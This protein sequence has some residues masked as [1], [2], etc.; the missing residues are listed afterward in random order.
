MPNVIPAS[1]PGICGICG[2]KYEPNTRIVKD[3]RLG[4]WVEADCLWPTK[5][6]TDY[7]TSSQGKGRAEGGAVEA[8]KSIVQKGSPS[9]APPTLSD[10][11]IDAIIAKAWEHASNDFAADSQAWDNAFLVRGLALLQA[12]AQRH[13]FAM[14]KLIQDNKLRNMGMM[15]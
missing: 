10:A 1:L 13:A 3:K 12:Q 15:K 6:N 8:R 4:K 14:S 7:A 9:E 2:K 11:E 5:T